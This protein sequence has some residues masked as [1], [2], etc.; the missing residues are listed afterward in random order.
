V[1]IYCGIKLEIGNQPIMALS[2]ESMKRRPG[3]ADKEK[4][5]FLT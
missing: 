2:I 4:I 1:K 3:S 5:E